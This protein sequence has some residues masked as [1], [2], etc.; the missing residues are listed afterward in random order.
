[1]KRAVKGIEAWSH[2]TSGKIVIPILLTIIAF[3][4]LHEGLNTASIGFAAISVA[5]IVSCFVRWP[6]R[7]TGAVLIAEMAF[8]VVAGGGDIQFVLR[9]TPAI[10]LAASEM[11]IR[12]NLLFATNEKD[13]IEYEAELFDL[14]NPTSRF[15]GLRLLTPYA[16]GRSGCGS[17][18]SA[19]LRPYPHLARATH[20]LVVGCRSQFGGSGA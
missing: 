9:Q 18:S 3:A 13:R 4:R 12:Q 15:N 8:G 14:E 10:A 20:S 11:P 19:D 16:L 7:I 6:V 2:T 1:M 17:I 5:L